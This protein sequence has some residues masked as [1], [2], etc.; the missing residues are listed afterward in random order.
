MIGTYGVTSMALRK[1]V[2]YVHACSDM[3]SGQHMNTH[4]VYAIIPAVTINVA[5]CIDSLT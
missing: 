3:M 4:E 1:Y 5:T 2:L